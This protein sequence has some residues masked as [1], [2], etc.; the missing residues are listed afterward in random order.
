MQSALEDIDSGKFHFDYLVAAV[1]SLFWFRLLFML[2]LTFYFGPLI[3][4]IANI[5][6]DLAKF[7]LLGF[8]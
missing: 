5:L 4:I 1:A 6:A 3:A 8:I 7:L 2:E